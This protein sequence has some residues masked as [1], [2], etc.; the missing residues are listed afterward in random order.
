MQ[1]LRPPGPTATHAYGSGRE[2]SSNS[3]FDRIPSIRNT[4]ALHKAIS[5]GVR[6]TQAR[7]PSPL[8]GFPPKDIWQEESCRIQ[9][10]GHL[11]VVHS[12]SG[13]GTAGGEPLPPDLVACGEPLPVAMFLVD[14]PTHT[15]EATTAIPMRAVRTQPRHL[16]VIGGSAGYRGTKG[17]GGREGGGERRRER[18]A[19][20]SC[21]SRA[22][23]TN[24]LTGS[25]TK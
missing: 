14:A 6:W 13:P 17:G 24:C 2:R 4:N 25:F 16:I 7:S 15:G 1:Y 8:E 19:S 5:S 11:G 20:P 3:R 12:V 10:H 18:G 22:F 9:D 21:S 23:S